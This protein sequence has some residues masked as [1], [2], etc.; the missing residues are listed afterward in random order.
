M[1]P[2]LQSYYLHLSGQ[3]FSL[4]TPHYETRPGI[5]NSRGRSDS[6]L[7][8]EGTVM[9]LQDWSG[10]TVGTKTRELPRGNTDR[11]TSETE[12]KDL[13]KRH[14]EKETPV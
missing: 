4:L 2:P 13:S 3:T 6:T 7:A 5:G 10:K 12:I 1:S 14:K 8:K 11:E 9:T